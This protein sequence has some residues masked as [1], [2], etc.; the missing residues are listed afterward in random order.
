M[1]EIQMGTYPGPFKYLILEHQLLAVPH[2]QELD[3]FGPIT[4]S[5]SIRVHA[6]YY[7]YIT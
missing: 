7:T 4:C 3:V 6:E 1:E 5:I 2:F